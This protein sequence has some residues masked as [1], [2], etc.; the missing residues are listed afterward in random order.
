[1]SITYKKCPKCN[2][3]NI[4]EE[5]YIN[6]LLGLDILLKL[7]VTINLKELKLYNN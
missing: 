5:G 3:A 2:G 6:G 1:M 4:D 7:G